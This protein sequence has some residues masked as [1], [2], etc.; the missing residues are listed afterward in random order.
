MPLASFEELNRRQGEAGERLFANPR[1]AGRRAACARRTRASPR[2]ATST[3]SRYQLGVHGGRPAPAHRT[4][5]RSRGCATLGFPVNPHIE[6]LADDRRGRTRS[7]S[8]CWSSV[9]RSA[10]RSTVRSSRSTTSPSATRWARRARRPAG[11][12]RT[13][14]RP[15]RRRRSCAAS[16]SAS[17]APG[18][19][20]RSRMLEPVFVG[21]STVGL[22]TLAQ[23]GR[24]RAQGRARRRHRDRAQGRRRHPRGR[25]PG[26]RRSASGRAAWK[27]PTHCP[28]CGAP[29]VRLEGEADHHCVNVECPEQRVQRIVLLRGPRRDGHRGARRGARPPVRRGRPARGRGRRLRAAPSSS[30]L[31]AR[32]H[33]AE[34]GR[35]TSSTG[36]RRRSR[37]GSRGCS[38]GLG[39]R[40]VGP[41][42]GAGARAR[43]RAPRRDRSARRVEELDGGRGRR[44]GDRRERRSGSSRSTATARWS[45]SCARPGVN[46]TAPEPVAVADRATRRSPGSTFV[47]TGGPRGLHPRRG[48]GRDR[49]AR[50]QG[51]R[52]RVEEDE[53]RRGGRE[54]RA[55]SSPRPSSSACRSSTRTAS[56]TCS[57]TARPGR[58]RRGVGGAADGRDDERSRASTD[59]PFDDADRAGQ[60]PRVRPGD[61]VATTPSTSTTRRP[62]IE[63]TFLTIG[64]LLDAAGHVACSRT[65]RSSTSSGCCTAARSTSSTGR[66]RAPAQELTVQTRVDDDLR[67]GRQAR[68]HDDVR[69]DG[70]RVPRRDRQARGRG[71]LDRDRDRPAAPTRGKADD[72][73]ATGTTSRSRAR[74]R[75]RGQSAR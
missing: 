16:W 2:R 67:E 74:G 53:L 18:A 75:S 28:V 23:R 17:V 54:S 32:A 19:R 5:R 65:G 48:A 64:E 44:P 45:R 40:H 66:R 13:S 63:P 43:A 58:A 35:A 71:A 33:G 51:H 52:Q 26:A 24:G 61:D 42:R 7:A 41:D 8:A 29:L 56:S 57:S 70:H 10:T 46:L 11:R 60:D 20:R 50:R 6:Q 59:E 27:F 39:I 21:G 69:R 9:T 30:S 15:R 12:S 37:S 38:S 36:S 14:S 31:A 1:N 72:G 47:L 55:R 62:S 68:R 3:S 22:A 34:V 25:R 73:A 4:T 49:G